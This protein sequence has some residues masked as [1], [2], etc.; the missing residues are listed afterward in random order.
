MNRTIT[1]IVFMIAVVALG[2]LVGLLNI[3][4][5]WY[6]SLQK[7]FFN[8][9][10]WLFG[11]A[12]TTLYILIGIAGARTWLD[13]RYSIRMKIWFV[14]MGLNFLWSPA[15][16]GLQSPLLGLVVILPLL[17][18]IL[19]FIRMSWPVDRIAAWLFVPYAL[20]VAFATLLNL[21]IVV[22]N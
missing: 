2:S 6:Q 17:I 7:P 10:N 3:P 16:F 4:G 11:P 22:L 9:P 15:F 14:Q 8:P 21:S 12:W 13:G 5:E 1:H 20:W 19:A 18:A